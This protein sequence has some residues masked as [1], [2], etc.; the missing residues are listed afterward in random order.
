MRHP[1]WL[2]TVSI[3]TSAVFLWTTL[4]T[5]PVQAVAQTLGKPASASPK[6]IPAPAVHDDP[7][8]HTVDYHKPRYTPHGSLIFQGVSDI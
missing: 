4:L 6:T 8:W 7:S 5:L 3:L 2:R 1:L